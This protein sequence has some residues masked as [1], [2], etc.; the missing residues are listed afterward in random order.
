MKHGAEASSL[1]RKKKM[2]GSILDGKS[3]LAVDD[4]PDILTTLEEEILGACPNCFFDKATTFDKARQRMAS[5]TYDLMILDIMGVNGFDL[6]E[7]ADT[8]NIPV[9]MFTAHDLTPEALKKS[10][11]MGAR[12]YLPKD[13]LGGIVPFLEDVLTYDRATGW[14]RLMNKLEG[15]FN[16]RWGEAWQ[17]KEARF[18]KEFNDKSKN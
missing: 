14:K 18:W 2:K 5:Y 11:E 4:E 15:F 6:L 9:V 7:R 3:I 13:K 17:K 8:K 16:A 10:I 1:G 12:A